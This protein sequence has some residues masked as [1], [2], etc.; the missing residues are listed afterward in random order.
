[1]KTR[2]L[3]PIL[4]LVLAVLIIAGSCA[5]D[6]MASKTSEE[7]LVGTW[8]NT[9]YKDNK[10]CYAKIIIQSDLYVREYYA[11]KKN[12]LHIITIEEKWADSDEN[13]WY[14]VIWACENRYYTLIKLSESERILEKNDTTND[15][16]VEIDPS[17]SSYRIYYRQ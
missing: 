1:M 16:P 17:H 8:I 3:I 14:K 11:S 6:K 5:T 10:L 15:Y 9:E 12:F 7:E 4:I 13:I 2:T